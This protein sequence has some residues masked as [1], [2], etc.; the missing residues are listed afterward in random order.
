MSNKTVNDYLTQAILYLSEHEKGKTL[1]SVAICW[2]LAVKVKEERRKGF[3]AATDGTTLFLNPDWLEKA[4]VRDRAFVFVHE[5]EHA[6]LRHA[7][8]MR[9]LLGDKFKSSTGR[10]ANLAMD[11]WINHDVGRAF[12]E[13]GSGTYEPSSLG[14]GT[15]LHSKFPDGSPLFRD[16]HD[17]NPDEHDW[18]WL[19]QRLNTS[20]DP[21]QGEGEG[22]EGDP[23]D[24]FGNGNDLRD[25]GGDQAIEAQAEQAA[26]RAL[27][28]GAA[29]AASNAAGNSGGWLDRLVSGPPAPT[30]DWRTELWQAALSAIPQEYSFR[31]LNKT[32]SALGACV[33]TVS[34]PG[35]GAI[36]CAMDTSG[37]ISEDMLAQP[38][39]EVSAICRDLKPE[40][41][42]QLWV[43]AE[44]ANVQIIEPGMPLSPEPKGGG[45]TDFK[46]A[47]DWVE[48]H[49]QPG[50]VAAMIYFTDLYANYGHLEDPGIPVIWM[51]LPGSNPADP[52][53][54]KVIRVK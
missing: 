26:A 34:R 5:T 22:G 3:T 13:D 30:H 9:C 54:G 33:G 32:Y 36:V 1:F 17:F 47:F 8:Q 10:R 39:A 52:P 53:F 42:Y 49:T 46:P 45:G 48:E 43:D 7:Q 31:R 50:E 12:S 20:K 35:L 16:V 11:G 6:I 18:Y 14:G 21:G 41:V 15:F 51:A 40:K 4:T 25:G 37:S 23:S 44:V 28:Q 38:I 24:G 29:R 2:L 19:Y 27:A